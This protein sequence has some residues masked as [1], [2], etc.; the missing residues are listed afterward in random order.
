MRF[1]YSIVLF[2]MLPFVLLRLL[3]RSRLAPAYRER[4]DERFGK[5]HGPYKQAG[6]WVHAVSVGEVL[7][8]AP[9]VR[10]LIQNHPSLHIHITTTTPTGSAQVQRLFGVEVSHSYAPYDIPL[11]LMRFL[12]T[13]RPKAML[14]V[15]TEVWPNLLH[16]AREREVTTLLA[17]ARLSA[18]SLRRYQRLES[19]AQTVFAQIDHVAAQTVADADR[20][21]MIGVNP[22]AIHVTGSIKFDVDV[23]ASV[24]E[25]SEVMRRMWSGRPVWV[26]GSTHDGEESVIFEAHQQL[27]KEVPDALLILVPRHPERFDVVGSLAE[28]YDFEV[29]RRSL[30]DPVTEKTQVYLG[31]TM[32]ELNVLIGAV[33]VAFIGGSFAKIGGHNVLEAA[34]QGIPVIV[35]PHTFNFELITRQLIQIGGAERVYNADELAAL[36]QAWL[37]DAAARVEVGE[38]GQKL[39]ADNRGALEKLEKLVE[40]IIA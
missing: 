39:V 15:E 40:K 17:N 29:S 16:Y 25:Q 5:V 37:T 31:D 35:G 38:A 34:A 32:G 14:M 18:R 4:W 3:W 28:R 8:V 2:L 19:F 33:N 10:H 6:L 24:L 21:R 26:A 13:L 11:F 30:H 1:F 36:L 12:D 7:A 23:P 9:L 20:L 22:A 27:I